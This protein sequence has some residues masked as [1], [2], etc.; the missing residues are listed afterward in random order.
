MNELPDQLRR[1]RQAANLRKADMARAIGVAPSHVT[2]IEKGERQPSLQVLEAWVKACGYRWGFYNERAMDWSWT[3]VTNGSALSAQHREHVMRL[4]RILPRLDEADVDRL[5]HDLDY[6]ERKADE[7]DPTA[8]DDV[9][10]SS[11]S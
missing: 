7:R 6:L 10:N 4:M 11:S 1:M 9:K 2:N 8:T 5:A 3:V